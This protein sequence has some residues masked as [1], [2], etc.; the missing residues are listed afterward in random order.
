MMFSEASGASYWLFSISGMS[1]VTVLSLGIT[2]LVWYLVSMPYIKFLKNE[3]AKKDNS[4]IDTLFGK[5]FLYT[6]IFSSS[7]LTLVVISLVW[8]AWEILLS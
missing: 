7:L 6:A 3:I 4:K 8:K 2:G 5:L 1:L